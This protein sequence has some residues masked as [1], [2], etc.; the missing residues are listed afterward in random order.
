MME[1][2]MVARAVHERDKATV[3]ER[4]CQSQRLAAGMIQR[5]RRDKRDDVPM[6]PGPA[7]L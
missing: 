3:L 1:P 4:A 6:G 2:V 7:S 5:L